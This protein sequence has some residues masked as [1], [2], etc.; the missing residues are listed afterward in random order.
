MSDMVTFGPLRAG[1]GGSP[2]VGKTALVAALC[3]RLRDSLDMVVVVDDDDG[4]TSRRTLNAAGVLEAD[5][6]GC[7]GDSL[8][9]A[10]GA[11]TSRYPNAQL[12]LIEAGRDGSAADLTPEPADVALQVINLAGAALPGLEADTVT[13]PDLLV[14]NQTD[15]AGRVDFDRLDAEL[16]RRRGDRPHVFASL[17][18]GEGVGEIARFLIDRGGIQVTEAG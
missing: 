12:V 7:A 5:R 14:I 15:R 10:I 16:R 11:L 18:T 6:I 17:E 3:R 2:G 13:R 4:G 1:I 9:A 8:G